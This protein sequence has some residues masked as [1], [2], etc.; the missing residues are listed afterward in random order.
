MSEN[1]GTHA[2]P[3]KKPAPQVLLTVNDDKFRILVTDA[4]DQFRL[5]GMMRVATL[6]IEHSLRADGIMSEIPITFQDP[7]VGKLSIGDEEALQ[8]A[9]RKREEMSKGLAELVTPK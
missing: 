9:L 7:E 6:Q 8:D 1:N 4:V 3:E 5:V 2:T